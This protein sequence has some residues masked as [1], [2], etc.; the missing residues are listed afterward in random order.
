LACFLGGVDPL[1][2]AGKVS[3]LVVSVAILQAISTGVNLLRMDP[4]FILA[5]WGFIVLA[6]IA[7]N[8]LNGRFRGLLGDL[9]IRAR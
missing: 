9:R 3:G 5:M 6:I 2:G 4:F 1:G 8:H 7:V